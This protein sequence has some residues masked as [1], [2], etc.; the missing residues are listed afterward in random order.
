MS[1]KGNTRET[2]FSCE[3]VTWIFAGLRCDGQVSLREKTKG[4]TCLLPDDFIIYR[5]YRNKKNRV[6][7]KKS[8]LHVCDSSLWGRWCSDRSICTFRLLHS[9]ASLHFRGNNCTYNFIA[10]IWEPYLL[11]NVYRLRFYNTIIL[12]KDDAYL[13]TQLYVKTLTNHNIKTLF[14][15]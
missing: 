14:T 2:F 4:K 15:H 7:F 13:Y 3:P 9:S 12:K 6:P 5:K 10:F 8:S 11:E 1:K